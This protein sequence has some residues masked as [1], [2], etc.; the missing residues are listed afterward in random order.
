MWKKR[1]QEN[2]DDGDSSKKQTTTRRSLSIDASSS[3]HSSSRYE[4]G[5][6]SSDYNGYI[7]PSPADSSGLDSPGSEGLHHRKT[8]HHAVVHPVQ[9]A[10]AILTN[11]STSHANS[12]TNHA[13]DLQ[14]SLA[15]TAMQ[16]SNYHG[17]GMMADTRA[18]GRSKHNQHHPGLLRG[19]KQN[20]A[21]SAW[22]KMA[23]C[24]FFASLLGY[25]AFF[26]FGAESL[27]KEGGAAFAWTKSRSASP[28]AIRQ[29][30]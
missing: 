25:V 10:A 13:M 1:P 2:N 9:Q 22:K 21:S 8:H 24:S 4:I 20:I 23:K 17:G 28:G 5:H 19:N 16:R 3:H 15:T 29:G 7:I 12:S 6:G 27:S 18:I 11:I 14:H 30:G 26:V